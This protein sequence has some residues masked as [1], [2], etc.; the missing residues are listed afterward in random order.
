[1]SVAPDSSYSV[2][3]RR[4]LALHPGDEEGRMLS[5]PALKTGGKVYGFA[6]ADEALIVKL[7]ASR[8]AELIGT[9][10]GDPCSPRPGR[11][12]REWVRIPATDPEA[13]LA[14]LLEARSFVSGTAA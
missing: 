13:C 3:A 9:G 2:A 6:D 4:V 11:P 14:Y 5:T 10:E 1:M 8:V 12:M 7:P